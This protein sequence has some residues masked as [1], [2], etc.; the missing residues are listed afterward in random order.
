MKCPL[1]PVTFRLIVKPVQVSE[2]V[3]GIIVHAPAEHK[4]AQDAATQG[5]IIAVGN[6]AGNFFEKEYDCKWIPK[7]G[8]YVL[9]KAHHGLKWKSKEG[10]QYLIL[11]D[12]DIVCVVDQDQIEGDLI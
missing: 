4:L 11:N 3:N 5:K 2:M 6:A 10:D 12:E 1:T 9:Y 7:L 8:D